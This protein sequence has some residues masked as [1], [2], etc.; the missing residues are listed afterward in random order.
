[1]PSP[2][3]RKEVTKVIGDYAWISGAVWIDEKLTSI[4]RGQ[5]WRKLD[6]KKL[7][8]FESS[9]REIYGIILKL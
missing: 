6:G 3:I 8:A 2:R 1:M 9:Q 4:S 5:I 7:G